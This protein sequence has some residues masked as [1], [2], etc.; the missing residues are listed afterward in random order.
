MSKKKTVDIGIVVFKY[1]TSK[2]IQSLKF[3]LS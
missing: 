2:A 3:R 1:Q